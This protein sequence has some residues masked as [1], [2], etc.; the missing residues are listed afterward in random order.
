[1]GLDYPAL[2]DELDVEG[3]RLLAVLADL[4][5]DSWS[6]PTPADR[7]TI[8]EQV[9]HL[10]YFDDTARTAI[11]DGNAFRTLQADL[12]THGADFP[13]WVADQYRDRSGSELLDWFTRA[14]TDLLAALRSAQP[15]DRMP[16]FGPDMSVA[17]CATARLMETFA[18]GRDVCDALGMTPESSPGLKSIAHLG[19]GTFGFAHALNKREVPTAPVRVEL[20]APDG[21]ET[22]SWGP[23]DAADRVTG[24]A[25]HFVLAVTQRRN[26]ADL[27]LTVT[28]PVATA[29]MGIAQIYA[30][31]PGPG[32][33]PRR[34]PNHTEGAQL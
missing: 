7:W 4:S 3:T 33:L 22:W 14:R 5:D 21:D 32:R 27:E 25:E 20:A 8:R 19:V 30:G 28:G 34:G 12:L 24:P 26:L 2:I 18:H 31:E 17:S 9:S 15:K 13:D 23:D 6:T 1:M 29:W 16:W 11:I 10:A